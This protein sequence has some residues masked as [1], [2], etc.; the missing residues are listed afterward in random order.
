M[1]EI[2]LCYFLLVQAIR[3]R[4][5]RFIPVT[6]LSVCYLLSFYLNLNANT[7]ELS[8]ILPAAEKVLMLLLFASVTAACVIGNGTQMKYGVP[9]LFCGLACIIRLIVRPMAVSRILSL[10]TENSEAALEIHEKFQPVYVFIN[11]ATGV[12]IFLMLISILWKLKRS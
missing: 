11:A 4:K 12:L 10:I 5:Y 7:V 9:V 3:Q 1:L 6:V 8:D 2:I